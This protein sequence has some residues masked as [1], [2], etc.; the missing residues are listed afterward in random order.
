[1]TKSSR[2]VVFI[3]TSPQNKRIQL[4]KPK[5]I[6]DELPGTST[7]IMSDN[8]MKRY[9]K[10]PA[11]LQNWCLADY[12]SQLDITY[13]EQNLLEDM[14][15]HNDDQHLTEIDNECLN[16]NDTIMTLKDGIT[17]R[18][19]KTNKVIRYVRFNK[20]TDE[21]NHCR[22]KLLLFHPWK[23]EE[24]DLIGKQ[25]TYKDQYESFKHIIEHKCSQYENHVDELD[26][27]R[28]IAEAEYNAFDEIAPGAQQMEAETAEEQPVESESFI[29]YNPD[30]AVDHIIY[31]I[32]HEI[33]CS[34]SAPHITVQQNILPDNDYRKLL[35]SLNS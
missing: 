32:G 15:D 34:V 30:R 33:G 19:R 7:D 1:M 11:A 17:I 25:K 8:V 21:E 10:R 27:A 14:D 3:N 24:T 18:R 28:D 6:L 22:E 5:K 16:E 35:R 9:A 26:I 4:L 31:D 23:N 12:V 2:D 29:Y 13:P 20:K